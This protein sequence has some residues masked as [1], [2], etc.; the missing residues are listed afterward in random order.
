MRAYDLEMLPRSAERGAAD[1]HGW[2]FGLPPGITPEQWPLDCNSGY[3]LMH[4]FTLLLPEDYRVHGPDIV[5]LS[6]F[7][8]A[9]DHVFG[10]PEELPGLRRAVEAESPEPPADPDFLPFWQAGR[11]AH[12]RL[13]RMQDASGYDYALILLTR[14]EFDGPACE[15]PRLAENYWLTHRSVPFWSQIGSAAAFF[16]PPEGYPE[17]MVVGTDKYV[18]FGGIPARDVSYHRA[19][20]W[21]P[22]LADPNAG[23][24]PRNGRPGEQTD[25]RLPYDWET[26]EVP[27]WVEDH[28]PDHIGGTIRN[29]LGVSEFSPFYIEFEE[30]MGGFDF[31]CGSARLDFRDMKFEWDST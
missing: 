5:A 27:E 4:A 16:G 25:Y 6:F 11:A 7:A 30:Y 3:P 31:E 17:A 12:P 28:K 26:H 22:R 21:T 15:P 23:V 13:H 14:E 24:P 9:P 2:C 18:M 8:T 1:N 20:R 29:F 10:D 19:L